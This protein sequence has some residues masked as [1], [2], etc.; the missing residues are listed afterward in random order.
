[1]AKGTLTAEFELPQRVDEENV[2]ASRRALVSSST[3]ICADCT[4]PGSGGTAVATKFRNSITRGFAAVGE[5]NVAVCLLPGT[6]IAFDHNV[7]CEPSF[8][9]GILPNK[10]IGNATLGYIWCAELFAAAARSH[11]HG[12]FQNG[13]VSLRSR[14]IALAPA[15]LL[16]ARAWLA[17]LTH[18]IARCAPKSLPQRTSV[19]TNIALTVAASLRSP[20]TVWSFFRRFTNGSTRL[21]GN[22]G[23]RNSTA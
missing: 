5:P 19:P 17:P 13:R 12:H 2:A 10:K 1:M 7:E 14:H 21:A 23:E 15:Q 20:K 22:R 6:E 16:S 4:T 11:Q 8:D 3:I 9:I 18:P